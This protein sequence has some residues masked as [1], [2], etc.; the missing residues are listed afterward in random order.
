MPPVQE[1]LESCKTFLERAQKRGSAVTI[2]YRYG[3][4]G[5]R[6]GEASNPG[7]RSFG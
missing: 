5:V 1:Q 2:E 3:L 4:R 7:P 6:V